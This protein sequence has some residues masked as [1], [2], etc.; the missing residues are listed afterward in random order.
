MT[1]NP[2]RRCSFIGD[3]RIL[4]PVAPSMP[5][6]GKVDPTPRKP[7]RYGRIEG[8]G[9][10]AVDRAKTVF[11]K[12]MPFHSRSN[13]LLPKVAGCWMR[14]R[15]FTG[16]EPV[17]AQVRVPADASGPTGWAWP[18]SDS[19]PSPARAGQ[20][21]IASSGGGLPSVP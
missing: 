20:I 16:D 2:P 14:F 11:E 15:G 18:L 6:P 10:S 8:G 5:K 19:A 9:K 13:A 7:V 17:L 3:A 21:Q 4:A 12:E 1:S